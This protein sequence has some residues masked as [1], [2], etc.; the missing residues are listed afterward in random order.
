MKCSYLVFQLCLHVWCTRLL[1]DEWKEQK[2]KFYLKRFEFDMSCDTPCCMCIDIYI[3]MYMYN[4]E[5]NV[6]VFV[7]IY[8][9]S[10]PFGPMED[11]KCKM[12]ST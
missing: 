10:Q 8:S 7:Y 11:V 12:V 3:Y 4:C 6:P 9:M 2:M 1:K 5:V